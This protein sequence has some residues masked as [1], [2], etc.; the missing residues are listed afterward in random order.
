MIQ[1]NFPFKF[2]NGSKITSEESVIR[3]IINEF[4]SNKIG[5][6]PVNINLKT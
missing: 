4:E 3:K 6:T 1:L 2:K 5:E